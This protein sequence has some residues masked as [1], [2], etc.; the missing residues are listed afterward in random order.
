M[1]KVKICRDP[2]DNFILELAQAAHA[3]FIIT[4]DKDL[5]EL[6]R[7]QW[8]NAQIVNPETFLPFLRDKGII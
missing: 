2:N 4:R 8:K 6:P 5:L 1:N 7:H 3:D